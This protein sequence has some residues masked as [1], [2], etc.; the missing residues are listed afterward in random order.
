MKEKQKKKDQSSSKRHWRCWESNPGLLGIKP[1][2]AVLT[3]ILQ[4]LD[5]VI[6]GSIFGTKSAFH[7]GRSS[8]PLRPFISRQESAVEDVLT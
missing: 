6:A 5:L 4:H 8:D 7:K 1:Q 3:T 2:R